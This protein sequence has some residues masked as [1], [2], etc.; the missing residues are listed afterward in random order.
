MTE[1]YEAKETEATNPD[2]F[3]YITVDISKPRHHFIGEFTMKPK[4][5][6]FNFEQ[7]FEAFNDTNKSEE[8]ENVNYNCPECDSSDI[9]VLYNLDNDL[10]KYCNTC[11]YGLDNGY[12]EYDT[13]QMW[14]DN[15]KNP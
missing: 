6:L 4:P 3:S 10:C 15:K 13:I 14:R 8:T 7:Y 9:N 11:K 2:N 1:L 12:N 5:K